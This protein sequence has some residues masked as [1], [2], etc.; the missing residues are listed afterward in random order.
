MKSK[1]VF[2]AVLF[3]FLLGGVGASYA[4]GLQRL[5][6]SAKCES[7]PFKWVN[8][9]GEIV[10]F[11]IDVVKEACRRAGII[12]IIK[13]V[14]WKRV[15]L[16]VESG[17]SDGGFSAFKTPAREFYA[18]FVT[19]YPI[20]YSTYSLFVLRGNEFEYN[21]VLDLRGKRIGK[22]MGYKISDE[23]DRAERT[24]LF[25]V[26]EV[27]DIRSSLNKLLLGRVDMLVENSLVAK[28]VI[29]EMPNP[30]KGDIVELPTPVTKRRGAYLMISKAAKIKNKAEVIERLNQALKSMSEDGT[31]DKIMRVYT[32]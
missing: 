26:D 7:P 16:D 30:K 1:W 15:L 31:I 5:T 4:D 29:R 3:L 2:H 27:E 10:G 13:N 32:Q 24:R 23:F 14:P 11:D 20:H 28:H 6:F 18:H 22:M 9:N 8:E 12:P 21:S 19:G 25:E 17:N